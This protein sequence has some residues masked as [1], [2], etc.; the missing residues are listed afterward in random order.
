MLLGCVLMNLLG[1]L[2]SS[3]IAAPLTDGAS[4]DLGISSWTAFSASGLVFSTVVFLS[5]TVYGATVLGPNAVGQLRQGTPVKQVEEQ[6]TRRMLF[7]SRSLALC[8]LAVYALYVWKVVRSNS[9]YY[10]SSDNPNA[11]SSLVYALQYHDRLRST[12]EVD[13]GSRYSKRFAVTR[14]L[15]CLATLATLCWVLVATLPATK[16]TTSLP[17][18]FTLAVLLPCVFE[19]GGAAASVLL[20]QAGRPDIAAGIAF[21]SIVH[22]YM[23]VLPALVLAGWLIL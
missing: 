7:V 11:P 9:N 6:R 15:A 1:V 23:F 4:V 5:P 18:S 8:V 20:S 2:G 13:L 21:T 17:L 19:A 10:V 16:T 12:R 3:I 14:A 22:L